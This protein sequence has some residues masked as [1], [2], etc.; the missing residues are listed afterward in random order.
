M[1]NTS[2]LQD[3]TS[4]EQ[5][6]IKLIELLDNTERHLTVTTKQKE[7]MLEKLGEMQSVNDKLKAELSE[8]RRNQEGLLAN[9]NKL[10][11]RLD[12]KERRLGEKDNVLSSMTLEKNELVQ[13]LAMATEQNKQIFS[14]VE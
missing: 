6:I 1:N 11:E 7:E 13:K 9:V 12:E 5:L 2:Q 4:Q 10:L 14:D 8:S 3:K